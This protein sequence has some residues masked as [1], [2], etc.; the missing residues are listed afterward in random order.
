M[1][2]VEID[3]DAVQAAD[4]FAWERIN[5]DDVTTPFS[6]KRIIRSFYGV[7]AQVRVEEKSTIV[8]P[9]KTDFWFS[10]DS[11]ASTAAI[12]VNYD[13]ILIAN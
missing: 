5:A 1:Q 12:G 3:A 13:L 10:G 7:T 6:A 11:A 2:N 8:L 4:V 9:A